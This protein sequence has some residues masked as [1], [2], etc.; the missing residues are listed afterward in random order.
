[1]TATGAKAGVE[2]VAFDA[3]TE[4]LEM[5]PFALFEVSFGDQITAVGSNLLFHF[6]SHPFGTRRS[7]FSASLSQV[8]F[9]N[10]RSSSATV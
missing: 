5:F 8:I 6:C 9:I 4:T 2:A 7:I 10:M 3:F 1:M